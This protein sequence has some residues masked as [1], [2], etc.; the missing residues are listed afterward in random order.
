VFGA[1]AA[2]DYTGVTSVTL[3]TLQIQ[4]PNSLGASGSGNGTTIG[5]GARVQL[6]GGITVAEDFSIAGT[7]VSG[8]HNNSNSTNTI[9]GLVT[10]TAAA[11]FGGGATTK[12]ILSGTG[13]TAI[14]NGGF[15][16]TFSGSGDFDVVNPIVGAGGL[17]KGG[18]GTLTLTGANTYAGTTTITGGAL[19]VRN[20]SA[21]GGTGSGVTITGGALQ[22]QGGISIGNEALSITG[23]GTG[24]T[25]SLRNISGNNSY[26]GA[27]TLTGV[28]QINSDADTLTLSGGISGAFGLT[29]GGSA[30]T[31][32]SGNITTGAGTLTKNGA[33]TL[34]MT[35]ANTFT[36]DTTVSTGILQLGN[37]GT[38]GSLATTGAI[39]LGGAVGG[40][41]TFRVNQSDTVTQGVDF[42]S[43][44]IT[45]QGGFT[46]V[47]S[48]TTIL[49]A[50]N[51][52]KGPTNVNAGTL[53]INGNQG[54]ANATGA[55]TV[56]SGAKLGGSGVIGG[57]V[58]VNGILSPG[59]S[60][61]VL[62]VPSVVL[63]ASSTSLF[64]LNGTTRGTDYD[65]L[66]IN[67]AG[68]ITYGG[69]LS[70]SFGNGTAF[71][72]ETTFDLFNF[73]GGSTGIFSSVTSTGFYAGTWTL[74]SGTWSLDSA[75]Q[76]LSFTPS[77]GDL[78]VAVPEP[79]TLVLLAG[80][81]VGG[82]FLARRRRA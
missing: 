44:A 29:I 66:N 11:S 61:G 38:G 52:Y 74:L 5:S 22:L 78:V 73:T 30:N 20:S 45:G 54:G 80:L 15:L 56:D 27:V 48:G 75:G 50:V 64:E 69:A 35:G 21:L 76:K 26:G 65:G 1:A 18:N 17:T 12:L 63:G 72:N 3:G 19:N 23:V 2:N 55:V 70:L 40:S 57:A 16:A 33:G 32:V 42:S 62:T 81:A 25:G 43:A 68:G 10:L 6:A 4:N 39:S 8:A 24:N 79:S 37:G 13:G 71:A 34:T 77:N 59:N 58:T 36:G 28:T 60:P 51:T 7:G 14:D 49:N 47:G 82:R 41:Q 67:D 9:T 31:S 46:Q 53:L